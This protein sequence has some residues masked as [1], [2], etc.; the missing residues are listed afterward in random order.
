V[1][2]PLLRGIIPPVVT[3]FRDDGALDLEAFEAN[4]DA[5]AGAGFTG[6]LV[7]GSNGEAVSLEE[8][9]KL[10][11]VRAARRQRGTLLVGTGMAT[12]RGT[13]ELT[14]KV[15]DL[16]ADAALVLTPHYYRS[17]MSLAALRH[18]YETLADAALIPVL[19]YS[20]PAVT[21]L[22]VSPEL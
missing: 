19:L 16:G 21:G 8:P 9:E 1:S 4:L 20:M 15:A 6:V 11:L 17:Q 18:H 13:V 5:Y 14:R 12:T 22:A 3:P 10:A 7:L 2:A